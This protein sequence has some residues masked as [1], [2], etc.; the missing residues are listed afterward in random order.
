MPRWLADPF[1]CLAQDAPERCVIL[2]ERN[3]ATKMNTAL[4]VTE[5]RKTGARKWAFGH[6]YTER[7]GQ[8]IDLTIY[9]SPQRGTSTPTMT[10]QEALHASDLL[11]A[12]AV[13]A[14]KIRCQGKSILELAWEELDTVLERLMTGC[15]AEDGR[16]PGRAEGMAMIIAIFLN[17]YLPNIESVRDEAMRRWEESGA[18]DE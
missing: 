17:P 5:D 14:P 9:T 7:V 1:C 6:L 12:A 13:N 11:R 8:A 15:E 2:V 4:H 18:E 10:P 3:E 16:D